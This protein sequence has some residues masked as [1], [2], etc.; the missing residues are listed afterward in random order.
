VF[1]LSLHALLAGVFALYARSALMRGAL[2]FRYGLLTIRIEVDRQSNYRVDVR[3]RR[4][5]S[6]GGAFVIGG[7]LWLGAGLIC[8]G[9]CIHFIIQIIDLL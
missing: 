1:L 5:I 3:A 8:A 7:L 9:L 6:E 2:F 4:Q